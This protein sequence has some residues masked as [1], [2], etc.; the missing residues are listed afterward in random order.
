VKVYKG[1]GTLVGLGYRE[2]KVTNCLRIEL[3]K[4][5]KGN[6]GLF[7]LLSVERN[8]FYITYNHAVDLIAD[9]HGVTSESEIESM[10][11]T[12]NEFMRVN[13]LEVKEVRYLKVR[14]VGK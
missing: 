9:Y 1:D 7:T 13:N 3:G 5:G 6:G 2:H 14:R 8:D 12:V 4:R 10:R 11:A